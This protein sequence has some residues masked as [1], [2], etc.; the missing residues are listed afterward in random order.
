ME[1]IRCP[2]SFNQLGVPNIDVHTK[3]DRHVQ[4]KYIKHYSKVSALLCRCHSSCFG[5]RMHLIWSIAI[6][7]D[8]QGKQHI[9]HTAIK[10]QR[11]MQHKHQHTTHETV[12]DPLAI[13]LHVGLPKSLTS[14]AEDG[15]P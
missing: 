6:A 12:H 15:R 11:R 8:I 5:A 4:G 7:F 3:K 9:R 2:F 10:E 13:S 1:P 14:G